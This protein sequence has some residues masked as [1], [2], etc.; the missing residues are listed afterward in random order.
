MAMKNAGMVVKYEH[1]HVSK[2]FITNKN[3]SSLATMPLGSFIALGTLNSQTNSPTVLKLILGGYHVQLHRD[4]LCECTFH[5][6][7]PRAYRL[8][9]EKRAC[10]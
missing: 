5:M 10:N 8:L 1:I 3:P 6:V 7:T 2:H 9:K 4:I